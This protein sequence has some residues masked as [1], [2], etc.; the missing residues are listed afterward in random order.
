MCG[1][2]EA[3]DNYATLLFF[4]RYSI[5]YMDDAASSFRLGGNKNGVF[6]DAY[7]LYVSVEQLNRAF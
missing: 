2:F 4:E 7:K 6:T 1:C 5:I 3:T